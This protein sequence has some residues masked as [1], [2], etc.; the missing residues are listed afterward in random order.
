MGPKNSDAW[1]GSLVL[2][3]CNIVLD[4]LGTG[5][6]TGG[7]DITGDPTRERIILL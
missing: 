7:V 1:N 6:R 4:G 2:T 5:I 3:A